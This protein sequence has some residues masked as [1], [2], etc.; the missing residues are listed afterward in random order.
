MQLFFLLLLVRDGVSFP[1]ITDE[2]S[3]TSHIKV[4]TFSLFHRGAFPE[5]A[6]Y[7]ETVVCYFL[8]SLIYVPWVLNLTTVL[9]TS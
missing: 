8:L 2:F 6:L 7:F 4:D 9:V 3:V 1:F 5:K